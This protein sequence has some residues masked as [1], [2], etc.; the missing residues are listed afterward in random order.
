LVL[1][2]AE[3]DDFEAA[4]A[5]KKLYFMSEGLR[6]PEGVAKRINWKRLI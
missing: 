1:G 6:G 5:E 4:I 2:G 3:L